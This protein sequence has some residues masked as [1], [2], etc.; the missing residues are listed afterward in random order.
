MT[1]VSSSAAA[2]AVASPV[3]PT[4]RRLG[5]GRSPRTARPKQHR[6]RAAR[7]AA[8]GAPS[9]GP[10]VRRSRCASSRRG[11]TTTSPSL[12]RRSAPTAGTCLCSCPTMPV[13][14][15]PAGLEGKSD[16]PRRRRKSPFTPA[17]L[18]ALRGSPPAPSG[19]CSSD[20][21]ALL[22][23]ARDILVPRVQDHRQPFGKNGYE[24][25]RQASSMSRVQGEIEGGR[26][27]RGHRLHEPLLDIDGRHVHSLVSRD[28]RRRHGSCA[29]PS[30]QLRRAPSVAEPGKKV[31]RCERRA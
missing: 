22:K 6:A 27:A 14:T 28:P 20:R 10:S 17:P 23:R 24:I 2:A 8:A 15:W 31:A 1:T 13:G 11:A 18:E 3:G 12:A 9:R 26:I 16:R 21:R 5:N 30:S 25:S 7:S 19:S 4:A 29:A